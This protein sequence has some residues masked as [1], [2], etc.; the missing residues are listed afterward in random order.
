M[1]TENGA[2]HCPPE[3]RLFLGRVRGRIQY[4]VSCTAAGLLKEGLLKEGANMTVK[5]M[6]SSWTLALICSGDPPGDLCYIKGILTFAWFMKM[7][8]SHSQNYLKRVLLLKLN[9]NHW[10]YRCPVATSRT[11]KR[12]RHMHYEIAQLVRTVETQNLQMINSAAT[13][14]YVEDKAGTYTGNVVIA[15]QKKSTHRLQEHFLCFVKLLTYTIQTVD[16]NVLTVHANVP[17]MC[18]D[19]HPSQATCGGRIERFAWSHTFHVVL[20][21]VYES[22]DHVSSAAAAKVTHNLNTS[23]SLMPSNQTSYM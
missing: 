21:S 1:K 9:S 15:I 2:V 14:A 5:I 23:I 4:Y 11:A 22:L 17:W 3:G 18:C 20:L 10:R 12:H 19:Y 8:T 13:K 7:T 6:I 16:R